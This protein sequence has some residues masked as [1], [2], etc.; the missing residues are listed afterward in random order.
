MKIENDVPMPKTTRPT[1]YPFRDMNVGES[2]FFDNE[3]KGSQSN[4]AISA[5]M[6]SKRT[7]FKF[8]TRK[9]GNGVRIW[10]VL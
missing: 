2:V 5:H 10:R 1:K 4:P 9:E 3:P 6:L 8:A 7:D